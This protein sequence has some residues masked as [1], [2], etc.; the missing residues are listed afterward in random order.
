MFMTCWQCQFKRL[1]MSHHK[2]SKGKLKVFFCKIVTK[3]EI[4]DQKKNNICNEEKNIHFENIIN[5]INCVERNRWIEKKTRSNLFKIKEM[6]T[7]LCFHGYSFSLPYILLWTFYIPFKIAPNTKSNQ[8][9]RRREEEEKKGIKRYQRLVCQ[10]IEEFSTTI[11]VIRKFACTF[12][13]FLCLH[14]ILKDVR[15][16]RLWLNTIRF[17]PFL[18]N[19]HWLTFKVCVSTQFSFKIKIHKEDKTIKS[20]NF[21]FQIGKYTQHWGKTTGKISYFF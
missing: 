3:H 2:K 10:S 8:K 16:M 6:T 4:G 5:A 14:W 17:P 12:S 15:M 9:R 1:E 7:I 18:S 19:K 21:F 20:K 11:P 13:H